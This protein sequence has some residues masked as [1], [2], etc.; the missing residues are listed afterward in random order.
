MLFIGQPFHLWKKLQNRKSRDGEHKS[1]ILLGT[2]PVL[3]Q[4]S[5]SC[6][7]SKVQY[8]AE[9]VTPL[10]CIRSWVVDLV[11]SSLHFGTA[12]WTRRFSVLYAA[13]DA[14]IVHKC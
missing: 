3:A 13:V 9:V 6:L 7:N 5:I 12:L 2:T 11:A 8:R 14:I 4:L 10:S 1:M